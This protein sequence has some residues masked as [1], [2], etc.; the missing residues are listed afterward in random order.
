M[1]PFLSTW[2]RARSSDFFLMFCS[3]SL[4]LHHF[5]PFFV[6]SSSIYASDCP[7]RVFKLFLPFL[8]R[9][10]WF[11]VDVRN[12]RVIIPLY[13]SLQT[14]FTLFSSDNTLKRNFDFH[15][16][17]FNDNYYFDVGSVISLSK[18]LVFI[19]LEHFSTCISRVYIK[20]PVI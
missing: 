5:M 2:D 11:M 19:P 10:E 8:F 6:Y 20:S 1:L 7:F 4:S 17:T 14:S 3:R 18:I 16:R 9:N 12:K 13:L 15:S